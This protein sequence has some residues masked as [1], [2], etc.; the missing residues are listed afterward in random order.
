MR[1]KSKGGFLL[2]FFIGTLQESFH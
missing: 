1:V 2:F